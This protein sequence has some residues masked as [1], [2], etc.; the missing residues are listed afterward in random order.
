MNYIAY[1]LGIDLPGK[2][3]N[4]KAPHKPGWWAYLSTMKFAIV[5]LIVL[6]ALS[7]AAMFVNE[8]ADPN[9]M[10]KQP[11]SALGAAGRLLFMIF[12]MEDPF[13]SWWYRGLMGVL[14]L[15]LFA[16][17]LERTPI[18]W[19]LWK[20]AASPDTSWV[21]NAPT[22]IVRSVKAPRENVERRLAHTWRWRLKQSDV[23]VGEHGRLA[24]WGPLLTHYGMLFIVVGALVTSFGGLSTRAGGYSGEVVKLEDMPFEV[25]IDSFRVQYYPLQPG[26][27]V[28]VDN[29]WIGKLAEMNADSTWI[30]LQYRTETDYDRVSMEPQYITNHWDNNRDRSNIKRFVSW[31][32][33]FE[34]G[35][36]VGQQE[37]AVNSPLRRDGYRFY[38]SSYDPDNPRF[39]ANYAAVMISAS[40]SASGT[41]H[42]L[43]L[44]PGESVQVP[45][46]TLTVAAGKLL[47]HFKL[48]ADHRAYSQSAEFANPAVE[49]TFRGPNG[50]EKSQWTFVKFPSHEAGPGKYTYKVADLDGES[51]GMEMATI[52]EIK[53][54]HGTG[55][56]WLGFLFGTVGLVLSFYFNHRVLYVEWPTD[57]RNHI[58]MIGLTRKTH[59]LYERD[60]DRLLEGVSGRDREE[61]VTKLEQRPATL[62]K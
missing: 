21:D 35:K 9:A 46:D 5:I 32:T 4:G 55:L 25:R 56:L 42:T 14:T 28:L 2:D 37:V 16:C 49:L 36:D 52:F 34:D 38:Q 43:T 20:R 7:L 47:P 22:A 58:R 45:G 29:Q 17:V 59:H 8:L 41:S 13:R 44:K 30:V 48:G 6:G 50:F 54:T 62:N 26:Q 19:R 24:M 10:A 60:I 57:L 40:D 33:I 39:T 27:W 11:T 18:V 31:V 61:S 12:Q 3:G 1:L 15:S 23:W 53:K 51:A